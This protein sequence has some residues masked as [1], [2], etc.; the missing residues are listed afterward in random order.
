MLTTISLPWSCRALM[1]V[2]VCSGMSYK[3]LMD[4][5]MREGSERQDYNGPLTPNII[6]DELGP[7]AVQIHVKELSKH[8]LSPSMQVC[9][10]CTACANL[11]WRSR[12][13]CYATGQVE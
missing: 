7:F 9:K 3:A 1:R 2:P 13:P 4:K 5:Q 12:P 8:D 6:V 11:P 10:R